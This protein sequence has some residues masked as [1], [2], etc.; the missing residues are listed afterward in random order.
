[1]PYNL[2]ENVE[3]AQVDFSEHLSFLSDH[4]RVSLAS[5]T[6]YKLVNRQCH[7]NVPLV[8]ACA[9]LRRTAFHVMSVLKD[10]DLNKR[11]YLK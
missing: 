7:K 9:Y 10:L 5:I 2:T 11:T 1:M 8:E 6:V 4:G 3:K